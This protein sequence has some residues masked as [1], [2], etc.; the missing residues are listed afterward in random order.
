MGRGRG[1]QPRVAASFRLITRGRRQSPG[2]RTPGPIGTAS[3]GRPSR[4]SDVQ[5]SE[6]RDWPRWTEVRAVRNDGA[7]TGMRTGSSAAADP[8]WETD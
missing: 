4:R 5:G 7:E 1:D 8:A 6:P 2:T 3:P